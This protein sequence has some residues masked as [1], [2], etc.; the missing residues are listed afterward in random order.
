MSTVWSKRSVLFCRGPW[1]LSME[2]TSRI[3]PS[4]LFKTHL[5]F[6][7][8]ISCWHHKGVKIIQHSK[9]HC[10]SNSGNPTSRFICSIGPGRREETKIPWTGGALSDGEAVAENPVADA[11]TTMME[12]PNFISG[13]IALLFGHYKGVP[14]INDAVPYTC[15]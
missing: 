12:P 4:S 8:L 13:Y 14:I 11:A 3:C 9:T 15:L 1:P 7:S 5:M 2:D 10:S 6:F